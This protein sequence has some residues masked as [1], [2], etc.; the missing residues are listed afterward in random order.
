MYPLIH[1]KKSSVTNSSALITS[2]FWASEAAQVEIQ[3]DT[4]IYQHDKQHDKQHRNQNRAY[5]ICTNTIR[6]IQPK[7]N[8]IP[9]R[10]TSPNHRIFRL[11]T[12]RAVILARLIHFAMLSE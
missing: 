7:H 10:N 6:I 4:E 9:T 3:S 2:A 1:R 8:P 11:T 5:V 12:S